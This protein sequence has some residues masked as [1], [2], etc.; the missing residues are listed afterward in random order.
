[1]WK[2][3]KVCRPKFKILLIWLKNTYTIVSKSTKIKKIVDFAGKIMFG[4]DFK[5]VDRK[6]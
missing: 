2:V 6:G 1:M 4:F 5:R 3:D